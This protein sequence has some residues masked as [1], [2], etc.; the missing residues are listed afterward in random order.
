MNRIAE[1]KWSFID[2]PDNCKRHPVDRCLINHDKANDNDP[3][4]ICVECEDG[5]YLE[6]NQ[7]KGKEIYLTQ[8]IKKNY[9]FVENTL[10]SEELKQNH[11]ILKYY[12]FGQIVN[13]FAWLVDY[14][15][16]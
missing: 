4:T 14:V 16:K 7:C 2:C 10:I 1:L 5:F 13:Y 6:D 3:D 8:L 11:W 15:P 12:L 9:L